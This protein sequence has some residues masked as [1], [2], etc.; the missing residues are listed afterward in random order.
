MANGIPL[1][2]SNLFPVGKTGTID[3]EVVKR[4]E[5]MRKAEAARRA[6]RAASANPRAK[7]MQSQGYAPVQQQSLS[8]PKAGGVPFLP[9]K[10]AVPA[11]KRQRLGAGMT[12]DDV[13]VLEQLKREEQKSIPAPIDIEEA[14]KL[15]AKEAEGQAELL[16]QQQQAA[17]Q[18]V[19]TDASNA[20][21]K[22]VIEDEL[23]Q[24][25]DI[26]SIA[27]EQRAQVEAKAEEELSLLQKFDSNFDMLT[28]GM[29]L[30]ASNDGKKSVGE[31]IG[32]ALIAAKKAKT[33]Q[34]LSARE[35]K[36]EG[37]LD[38]KTIAETRKL[39]AQAREA[40]KLAKKK[41]DAK[42][43]KPTTQDIQTSSSVISNL[44]GYD[45]KSTTA[46]QLGAE[47][48]ELV[49]IA[50]MEANA[51]G[52]TVAPEVLSNKALELMS[53]KYGSVKKWKDA[54]GKGLFKDGAK[55]Q[56]AKR[57]GA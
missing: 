19:V 22:K 39:Q 3:E 50:R 46:R 24:G 32:T 17:K 42:D 54:M 6:Q 45:A 52:K 37:I 41:Y 36:R 40:E 10:G 55:E 20:V 5:A 49:N 11:S 18:Q 57:V 9:P 25:V 38:A 35:A 14:T 30:L 12:E 51:A 33:A 23:G 13:A 26:T 15:A 4:N 44:L 43:Y 31:N 21:K 56:F 29:M 2:Q 16:A 28:L 47:H 27:P 48:A 8:Q 7:A 1:L 34:A 53:R